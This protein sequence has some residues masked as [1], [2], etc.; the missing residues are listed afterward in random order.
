MPR[1]P[2]PPQHRASGNDNPA[3]IAGRERIIDGKRRA[4]VPEEWLRRAGFVQAGY[5][6]PWLLLNGEVR[7]EREAGLDCGALSSRPRCAREAANQKYAGGLF[8]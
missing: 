2:G 3:W 7:V 8:R 4:G 5:C 1:S 6:V